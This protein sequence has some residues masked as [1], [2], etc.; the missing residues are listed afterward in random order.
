MNSAI[1]SILDTKYFL[2]EVNVLIN[3]SV[4]FVQCSNKTKQHV[5]VSIPAIILEVKK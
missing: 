2:N 3:T 5:V 1:L 4:C